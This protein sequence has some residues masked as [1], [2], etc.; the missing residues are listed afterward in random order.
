MRYSGVSLYPF[1]IV[2]VKEELAKRD[3][4]LEAE[5][6]KAQT[7][8]EEMAKKDEDI[9]SKM[10]TIN[11]LRNLGRRYKTLST[12]SEA[13]LKKVSQG[14]LNFKGEGVK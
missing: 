8:T 4:E 1:S 9:T 7:Q 5:I 10:S 6:A 13:K 12:E 2:Q 11:Q 3:A 14:W